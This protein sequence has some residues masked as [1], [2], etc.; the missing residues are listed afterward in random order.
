MLQLT[1]VPP[2]WFIDSASGWTATTTLGSSK[3]TSFYGVPYEV[4]EKISYEGVKYY[5][6]KISGFEPRDYQV[7][8]VYHS[9][10]EY[11]KTIVSPTGSGKSMMIYAI[12]R[13]LAA[14]GK[15]T[16]IVVPTKMLV[17]QMT[18]TSPSMAGT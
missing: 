18:R 14:T 5:M 13:Y 10:K 6:S 3:T 2:V 4:D 16:L 11:R 9:L 1:P 17:E 12:A 15:R 8:T 7:E